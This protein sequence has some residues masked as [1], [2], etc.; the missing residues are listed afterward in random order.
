MIRILIALFVAS[1]ACARGEAGV[2][3]P[4]ALRG[5]S[6]EARPQDRA[7]TY[8]AEVMDQF[9]REFWVYRDGD[10][11]GNHFVAH[12]RMSN[13]DGK[14]KPAE[15][16]VML[17]PMLMF[18]GDQPHEGLDCI[19]ACFRPSGGNDWGAWY[20]MNGALTQG[21]TCPVPNWGEHPGAG[22]NLVG[23]DQLSFWARGRN[24]G[25]RVEFFAL[26]VGRKPALGTPLAPHPDSSPKR[27]L[28][29]VALT[30]DWKR[31]VLPLRDAS[32]DYVLGGFGWAVV[33]VGGDL[34]STT[35]YLDAISIGLPRLNEPRFLVSYEAQSGG[36]FVDR[37]LRNTAYTYDNC[38]ALMAFL[39]AG[40]KPRAKIIADA[41][42]YAQNHDRWYKDGSLRNAYQAGDLTTPPGWSDDERGRPVRLPGFTAT[43]EVSSCLWREDE[44]CVSRD[45]GNMAWAMLGLLAYHEAVTPP[46]R[47]SDYLRAAARL[48]EWVARNCADE[49][50]GGGYTGGFYGRDGQESKRSYKATEHNVDLYPAF[51]RLFLATGLVEWRQRAE[52]ARKF[53]LSMW[54]EDEGKFWTGTG[55]DGVTVNKEAVPVDIQAWALLA[56][57]DEARPYTR[58][59]DYAE[60]EIRRGGGY[61]FS[62]TIGDLPP[63]VGAADV[64]GV[65]YEGTAQMATA[66]KEM[67]GVFGESNPEWS[68]RARKLVSFL[69]SG[70]ER[71]GAM[72]ACD[73]N[74]WTGFYLPGTQVPWLYYSRPHVGAT[75]WFVL[76][77]AAYNPYWPKLGFGSSLGGNREVK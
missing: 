16:E 31:Y 3:A 10:A 73:R 68:D 32:L 60:R 67:V 38:L 17:P 35:F 2:R 46:G 20:F 51:Q 52:V 71:S 77:E 75:A 55:V 65:W 15:A 72:R 27:S 70:Q 57:K 53:I 76:A 37:V 25:E 22:L 49:K 59:L 66:Y 61:G 6:P 21:M 44:Y 58:A 4:Q 69:E 1:F 45:T 39:A 18:C 33:P 36:E 24:G 43:N 42:V 30:K 47:D 56:L 9:H 41:L 13:M 74:L 54:D 12:A 26:G 14:N 64:L 8:L 23:A 40:D 29:Q 48:G 11:A 62:K 28:G 34:R 19:E 63:S 7:V 50:G 5:S